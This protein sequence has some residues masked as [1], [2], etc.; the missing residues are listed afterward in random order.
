MEE[1]ESSLVKLNKTERVFIYFLITVKTY[2]LN[3]STEPAFRT[4]VG[5]VSMP[6]YE[7]GWVRLKVN[8]FYSGLTVTVLDKIRS[9][10]AY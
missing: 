3:F 4:E 7:I 8:I 9:S 6:Y 10:C 5:W 1:K 2:P